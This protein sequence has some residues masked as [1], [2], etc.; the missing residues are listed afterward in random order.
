MGHAKLAIFGTLVQSIKK[1]PLH[2]NSEYSKLLAKSEL[3]VS[4]YHLDRLV[5]MM[6]ILQSNYTRRLLAGRTRFLSISSPLLLRSFTCR[7]QPSLQ[8]QHSRHK[9]NA[10][11]V[12]T[13]PANN[14]WSL[15]LTIPSRA[16]EGG[17]FVVAGAAKMASNSMPQH[18]LEFGPKVQ[19]EMID[20]PHEV[21][22]L[23]DAVNNLQSQ[24]VAIV[25]VTGEPGV[26]K[27][28]VARKYAEEYYSQW[29][30]PLSKTA[31]TLD[32][33]NF[34]ASY[35]KLAGK[36]GTID[37]THNQSLYKTAGEIKAAMEYRSNWLMIVDN[38]N[39]MDIDGFYRGS[40]EMHACFC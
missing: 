12:P 37:A 30:R 31:L 13:N 26:G 38:Y 39:S 28:Q 27:T 36:I 14:L 4:L 10:Q 40:H 35:R 19:H 5:N 21:K 22:K 8:L 33:S 15:G 2:V 17:A 6:R 16:V 25:Y 3:K 18:L 24:E 23:Y 7:Q 1:T 20:R 9:L 34:H 32:M 29:Y 11:S